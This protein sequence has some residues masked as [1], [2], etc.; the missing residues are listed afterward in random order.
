M[1][2]WMGYLVARGRPGSEAEEEPFGAAGLGRVVW[3][4]D[5]GDMDLELEK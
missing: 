1:C 5:L 3:V 4:R 2:K